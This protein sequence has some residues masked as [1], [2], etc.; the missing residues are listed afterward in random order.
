MKK[1]TLIFI[2]FG[3]LFS[4][5]EFRELLKLPSLIEH[6]T[7][8]QSQDEHI[9]F[10]EFLC[11]HYLHTQDNDGDDAEDRSLPF[12]SH[13]NC[14]SVYS[15]NFYPQSHNIVIKPI[16][17]GTSSLNSN[18]EDFIFNSFQANIWQPPKI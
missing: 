17:T 18:T 16:E 4:F 15:L 11:M 6:F 2:L 14:I 8:H 7:E 9:S 10:T 1:A 13:S 3:Y 5:T 12:K